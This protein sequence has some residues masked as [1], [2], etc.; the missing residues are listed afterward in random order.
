MQIKKNINILIVDDEDALREVLSNELSKSGYQTM[1][2]PD[3]EEAL[4]MIKKN[5][6][7]LILL[8]IRMPKVEGIEVL[9][10]VHK[11]YPKTKVIMMTGFGD[12]KHAMEAKEHG[13]VDFITKPFDLTEVVNTINNVL[14]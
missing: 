3:G 13:A 2:A 4:G 6:F 14:L 11:N 5:N 9:K 10:Y 1:A 7:D 8:D 12:L